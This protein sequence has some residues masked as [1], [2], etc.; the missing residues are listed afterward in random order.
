MSKKI[1]CLSG[2]GQKHNSLEFIFRDAVFDPF[3]SDKNSIISSNYAL[4]SGIEEFFSSI[5]SQ[6]INPDIVIGWSLGGQLA[7]RLI[8]KKILQP[9][10]LILIAPPFQ[11]IKDSKIQSGMSP[12]NFEEFY[13]NFTTSPNKTLKQFAIL[14][15]MNDRNASEIA[16]NLDI[17]DENFE[18]LKFWLE[19]LKRFSCFEVD[20]SNMPKTL[21]FQGAGDMIVHETQAQYF[22]ERIGD[23]H[24]EIFKNCGHA[25]HL[26]DIEKMRHIIM[27]Y[28]Y[29]TKNL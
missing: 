6:N 3:F 20:F 5:E 2:W 1:L 19:E 4:F 29:Q 11:M 9:K 25:P 8:E 17:N 18:Q 7:I 10:L 26:S 27:Q 15:A 28:I 21:F 23:F 14:S 12:R 13:K 24:L 22:K 16:K